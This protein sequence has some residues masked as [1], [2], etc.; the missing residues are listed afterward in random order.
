MDQLV[1]QG[2]C[3]RRSRA[4][5]NEDDPL[6]R[7]PQGAVL[8]KGTKEQP[9]ALPEQILDGQLRGRHYAPLTV[10]PRSDLTVRAGAPHLA[11]R[12]SWYTLVSA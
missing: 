5:V 4:W 2:A 7:G 10:A 9:S 1:Q 3:E 12:N 8:A 6:L 11:H